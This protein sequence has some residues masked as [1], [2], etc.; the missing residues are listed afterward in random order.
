MN[1]YVA[2]LL[3][4]ITV[5]SF[6]ACG[7]SKTEVDYG[8]AESFEAA[9]N[10]GENLEGKTLMF[11]A[12]EFH[13]ES[14]LGYNIWAGEHLNFVSEKNPDIKA[15]DTVTV[16]I[17]EVKNLMGSWVITYEKISNAVIGEQTIT[18]SK[19][20]SSETQ[21]PDETSVNVDNLNE[22]ET[23]QENNETETP[24]QKETKIEF[25]KLDGA[26]F[27]SVLGK[28]TVSVYAV[29]KNTGTETIYISDA[30]IDYTD[31]EGHLLST[32]QQ[33]RCIPEAVKPGQTAYI[34]SYYHDISGVDLSKGFK[35][36]PDGKINTANKYYEI[37][38]S[39]VSFKTGNVFDIKII[40][41][42]TNNSDKDQNL[43]LVGAVFFDKDDKIVGCCYGYE[44]F[45]AGQTK[46]F[47]ITGDMLSEDYDPSIVDHVEVFIQ[48]NAWI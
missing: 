15:G 41:R 8:D 44:S 42:G 40:G 26:A 1:K 12:A 21:T 13:P 31:D 39:D 38:V 19:T 4:F 16:K 22:D 45:S 37:E 29:Y 34:F 18:S 32:D 14:A 30:R 25:L 24:A 35:F 36:K 23:S 5:I 48:G 7:A 11:T 17:K 10:R 28:P 27:K 47:E 20:P 2:L 43:A 9:L 33:A 3:V 46:S 6:S